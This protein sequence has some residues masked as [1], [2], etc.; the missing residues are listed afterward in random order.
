MTYRTPVLQ[1][2]GLANQLVLGFVPAGSEGGG[3]GNTKAPELP[4]GLDD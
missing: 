2:V 1:E 4:L 3:S